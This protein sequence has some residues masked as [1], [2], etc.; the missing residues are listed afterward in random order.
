MF[1]REYLAW[2]RDS[3]TKVAVVVSI[4][5]V[6]VVSIAVRA[7]YLE[8]GIGVL[9]IVLITAAGAE[10][11]PGGALRQVWHYR[12]AGRA[13][14]VPLALRAV[15][16]LVSQLL[17][18]VLAMALAGV[19]LQGLTQP[20]EALSLVLALASVALFAGCAVPLDP[21]ARDGVA[22]TT[23]LALGLEVGVV[24]VVMAWLQ[25]AGSALILVNAAV[26]GIAIGA[27]VLIFVRRAAN[28]L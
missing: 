11:V 5:F 22:A 2:V 28:A 3:S 19:L 23:I 16:L 18:L 20:L 27:A 21:N 24:T 12:V 9:L 8:P 26:A 1:G 7:N 10:T 15:P 14:W 4:L 17:A 13:S 6:A 25:L